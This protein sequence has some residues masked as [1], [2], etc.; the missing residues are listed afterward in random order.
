MEKL[1]DVFR[2]KSSEF[3]INDKD[4]KALLSETAKQVKL[5]KRKH[6]QLVKIHQ[7]ETKETILK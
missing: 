3:N 2:N 7:A 6:L 1:A 4:V 5:E